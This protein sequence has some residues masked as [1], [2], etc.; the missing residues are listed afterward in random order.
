[1][2]FVIRLD[3]TL[4][5]KKAEPYASRSAR[6]ATAV[7]L[8]TVYAC[9]LLYIW[10]WQRD[11][12]LLWIPLLA[13]VVLTHVLH[14]DTLRELGLALH[15]L[16]G[17]AGIILPLA[18]AIYGPIV[19]Y[20]LARHRLALLW[21]GLFALQRF[22]G[23]VLWCCFQQ[24]LAQSYFHRRLMQVVKGRHLRSILVGIMFGGAHLP[25]SILVVATLVGG[26]ILAE[27]FAR[28]P[29]IWPLALAQA[30]G[31][32]LL[33]ALVPAPLIHNMRVGPGYYTYHLN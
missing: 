28:H 30:V 20:A 27:V 32:F 5:N 26:V 31:G 7:E 11:V 1:M 16:R 14:H 15:E 10:R 8:L 6:A 12:P 9:I 29:N 19:I 2:S 4:A 25:N 22:F 23:Y 3:P 21:P 18:A 33:A 24:Y 13:F 17:S